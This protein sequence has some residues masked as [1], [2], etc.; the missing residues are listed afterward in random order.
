MVMD[1]LHNVSVKMIYH[2]QLDMDLIIVVNLEDH[3]VIIFIKI[4]I[5]LLNKF[6]YLLV[7][8]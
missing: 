5:L 6:Q 8:L 3:G 7:Y 2:M 1:N 4:L